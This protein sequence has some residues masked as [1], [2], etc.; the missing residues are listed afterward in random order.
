MASQ[1]DWWQRYPRV[2]GTPSPELAALV[3]DFLIIGTPKAGTSWLFSVLSR[4]PAVFMP[5]E[6]ELYYFNQRWRHTPL[7]DYLRQFAPGRGRLKGEAT[8]GYCVLPS[9][10]IETIRAL[11][12]RMKVILLVRNPVAQAWSQMKH[13]FRYRQSNFANYRCLFSN[14]TPQSYVDNFVAD[15]ALSSV[16]HLDILQRWQRFFP[17]E[18]IWVGALEEIAAAPLETFRSV[19]SFLS[20]DPS[21]MAADVLDTLVNEGMS[22]AID[23]ATERF[24]RTLHRRRARAFVRHLAATFGKDLGGL[25]QDVLDGEI[26]PAP[27]PVADD[28]EGWRIVVQDGRLWAYPV[29]AQD[30]IQVV[31]GTIQGTH[32]S[33][34]IHTADFQ[35][36]IRRKIRQSNIA[37]ANSTVPPVDLQDA[38]S[39]HAA[40]DAR[41]R[42]LADNAVQQINVHLVAEDVQG[43]GDYVRARIVARADPTLSDSRVRDSP[44]F[45]LAIRK[46]LWP[47]QSWMA[48]LLAGHGLPPISYV[49]ADQETLDRQLAAPMPPT[50]DASPVLES[51]IGDFNIIRLGNRYVAA[52]QSLGPIDFAIPLDMLAGVFPADSFLLN[53]DPEALRARVAQLL[54]SRAR[55][56]V[57]PTAPAEQAAD[58]LPLGAN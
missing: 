35:C 4:H 41:L 26:A 37:A 56:S 54:L 52:R 45:Y 50:A 6:K 2:V 53:N 38:A 36:E 11:N 24:L 19:L 3:P 34:P 14:L 57:A 30:H 33:V 28:I 40:E 39:G 25:W 51:S 1:S 44:P 13:S 5:L 17:A 12:P 58:H 27:L 29:D 32:A 8:P 47:P 23:N 49:A 46:E 21:P 20:L 42:S 16:D 31:N 10:A 48:P 7:D 43:T 9:I 22:A 18:D 55:A 15:D